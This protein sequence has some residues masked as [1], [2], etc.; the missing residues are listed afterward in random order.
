[1]TAQAAYVLAT[2]TGPLL[3]SGRLGQLWVLVSHKW[4]RWIAGL[5]LIAGAVLLPLISLPLALLAGAG[6]IVLFLG[7]KSRAGWA[8]LPV[9][10]LL[11]HLAYLN[12]LWRAMLGDRYV[13]WKP[14][15]G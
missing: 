8:T 15:E 1:M 12:G 10:F 2:Q 11:V 3:A 9:Y 5:W 6:A 7:W 4:L 14:R 13:V